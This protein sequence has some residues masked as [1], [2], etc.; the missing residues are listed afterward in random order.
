MIVESI[1][2]IVFSLV[3]QIMSFLPNITWD[4]DTGAFSYFLDVV[5]VVC[6]LFP[7]NTVG[8]IFGIIVSL[9]GFRIIVTLI[10]TLWDILPIV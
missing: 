4:V 1:L 9:M 10:K 7:M 3:E 5:Q 2:G 6:Y 8:R